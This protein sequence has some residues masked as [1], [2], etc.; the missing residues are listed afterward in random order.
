MGDVVGGNV[1]DVVGS[2]VGFACVVCV[3]RVMIK[4]RC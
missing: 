1:G 2:C 4:R 3:M